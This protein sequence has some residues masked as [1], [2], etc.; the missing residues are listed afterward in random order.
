MIQYHFGDKAGLIRAICGRRAATVNAQR[1]R[2]LDEHRRAGRQDVRSLIEA[3]VA[4]LADQV[5]NGTWYV[6]FLA[7]LQAEHQRDELLDH[8]DA[9]VNTAYMVVRTQLRT[10]HLREVTSARFAI[11]WRIA[12][13]LAIDALADRQTSTAPRRPSL[14]MFSAELIDGIAALLI[15]APARP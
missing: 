12:I 11:R 7:R 2:L 10:Q 4:P 9:P 3:Y 6:R 13:N 1:L 8:A 5:A 15:Q 14:P